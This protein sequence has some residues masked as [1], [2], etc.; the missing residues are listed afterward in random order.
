[1]TSPLIRSS[2]DPTHSATTTA[3]AVA[4]YPPASARPSP[5]LLPSV[6][7]VSIVKNELSNPAG[8]VEATLER[9]LPYVHSAVVVD[10]GSTDG[11][12][13]ALRRLQGRHP[14][15]H[16]YEAAF[17]S[18]AQARNE[19]FA[20]ALELQR[21]LDAQRRAL[22]REARSQRSQ[23]A[24]ACTDPAQRLEILAAEIPEL[25]PTFRHLLVLD[26]DESMSPAALALLAKVLQLDCHVDPRSWVPKSETEVATEAAERA[27]ER[28]RT[29]RLNSRRNS[30]A[31]TSASTSGRDS[32]NGASQRDRAT[33]E[34]AE[35]LL[36]DGAMTAALLDVESPLRHYPV[37]I[38]L[39][40]NCYESSGRAAPRSNSGLWNP[41][42]LSADARFSFVNLV[43]D[44]RFER[45]LYDG[46]EIEARCYVREGDLPPE[47]QRQYEALRAAEDDADELPSREEDEE[48]LVAAIDALQLRQNPNSNQA[49]APQQ[50]QQQQ[51][52]QP[53]AHG[54]GAVSVNG[55]ARTTLLRP[56][57]S[58]ISALADPHSHSHSY[59]LPHSHSHSLARS[60]SNS[61]GGGGGGG[62]TASNGGGGGHGAGGSS[63]PYDHSNGGS[64][65]DGAS[66]PRPGDPA[67]QPLLLPLRH[68][69]PNLAG[70]RKKNAAYKAAG[71]AARARIAAAAAAAAGLDASTFDPHSLHLPLSPASGAGMAMC[72]GAGSLGSN[73]GGGAF[74]NC[75]VACSSPQQARS[76]SQSIS[77]PGGGGGGGG[78]RG[79]IFAPSSPSAY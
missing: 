53:H 14:H 26:A 8:G 36:I 9:V 77:S 7:S 31:S 29:S 21:T 63:V 40:I 6:C 20:R 42:V 18:F 47:M 69:I 56:V 39:G 24:A 15:L 3:A 44:Y 25:P 17:E 2:S 33:C 59:S 1:M 64:D 32:S 52:P 27:R 41:R 46:T 75:Y 60:R 67:A 23:R 65:E 37:C 61:T 78:S 45:L 28:E 57:P 38:K 68:H 13:E 54:G 70:R 43:D 72:V 19:S 12:L 5:P 4:P 22:L 62:A 71:A 10:T 11:T 48:A 34:A 66:S 73:G 16:V 49:N 55:G 35:S 51:P 58:A 74:G 50:Q 79:R 30:S 76:R